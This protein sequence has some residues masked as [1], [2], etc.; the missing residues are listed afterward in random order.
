M[1]QALTDAMEAGV[2]V[3]I[4]AHHARGRRAISVPLY[5]RALKAVRDLED[6]IE[7]RRRA[8]GSVH[9]VAFEMV[10]DE[11]ERQIPL[12]DAA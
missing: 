1:R 5:M 10:R 2:L 9:S 8:L 4:A 6:A 12:W 3:R 11:L 7:P